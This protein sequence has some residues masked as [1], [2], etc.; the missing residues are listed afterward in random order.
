MNNKHTRTH[1][2]T[3]AVL[4]LLGTCN[5]GHRPPQELNSPPEGAPRSLLNYEPALVDRTPQSRVATL[6]R[7]MSAKTTRGQKDAFIRIDSSP[8]ECG[9]YTRSR[10][11]GSRCRS[12]DTHSNIWNRRKIKETLA[13]F[14][15]CLSWHSSCC[16][17]TDFI[18]FF[19]A[20]H[21]PAFAQF[22]LVRFSK[23]IFLP[24]IT[25]GD[26]GDKFFLTEEY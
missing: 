7:V 23:H 26:G 25:P 20:H 14:W 19:F 24:R 1:V 15:G 16:L 13:I 12:K 6:R 22:F 9:G 5:I 11:C 8:L 18:F 17:A 3:H 4:C 2:H 10:D 21:F